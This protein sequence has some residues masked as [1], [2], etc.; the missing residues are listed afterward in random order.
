MAF[1]RC[2]RAPSCGS[3]R[4][5]TITPAT[6][7]LG[8]ATLLAALYVVTGKLGLLLAVPPGYATII[9]P[10]SGIAIGMLQVHGPRLWPAIL[11]GSWLLNAHQS[12]AFAESDFV[13]RHDALSMGGGFL[14]RSPTPPKAALLLHRC[15]KCTAG[16]DQSLCSMESNPV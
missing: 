12:G 16:A 13:L 15:R 11:F 4:V 2:E 1:R 7:Y 5:F 14:V 6:N 9:W 3:L 8:R 10:A